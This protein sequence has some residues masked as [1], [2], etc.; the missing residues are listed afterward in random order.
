VLPAPELLSKA[1]QIVRHH[2]A[3]LP[4]HRAMI[5]V[6]EC[7]LVGNEDLPRP[8]L[9]V[10]CGDGHFGEVCL[11]APIDA[12]IDPA[13]A[14]A[15]EARRRGVYR[16]VLVGSGARLPF[17]DHTFATVVSNCVLEHIPALDATLAEIARVLRPGGKLVIT[18]PSERFAESLFWSRTLWRL[19]W[20]DQAAAYGRWFNRISYHYHTYSR[21]E[22][23]GRL[24]QAGLTVQSWT[25]YL[26]PDAM[27]FF[28]LS[29]Y[30]GAPTLLSKRLTGRWILW[31]G[32]SR[33]LPWEHWL[34]RRLEQ[35]AS[36]IAVP[37]GAY[38]FFTATK[39]GY[40]GVNGAGPGGA[41]VRGGKRGGRRARSADGAV[42]APAAPPTQEDAPRPATG[43][44][45]ARATAAA[46]VATAAPPVPAAP[47]TPEATAAPPLEPV[48]PDGQYVEY[49]PPAASLRDYLPTLTRR[50]PARGPGEKAA[51]KGDGG[52][53]RPWPRW[54]LALLLLILI[55]GAALRFTGVNWDNGHHLHP[56]ERFLTMVE[57][58]IKPGLV[59]PG[60]RDGQ[61]TVQPASLLD[62]YFDT[63]RSGLNPHN[64]GFGFFVYGT[65]PLFAVRWLAEVLQQTGYGQVHLLGRTL[66][67]LS[68]LATVGLIYLIGRRLYGA[69]VGLLAAALLAFCVMHIQQA[70]FFVFDSFLVTLIT[71]CFYACVDVAETGRLRSFALAG[72]FLGL[73]L[74]TKLSMVVFAPI[75]ALAGLIYLWRTHFGSPSAATTPR[76]WRDLAA[77]DRFYKV[78]Y[79]GMLAVAV[80]AL[81]FRV[82]QPYA[83]SGPGF[84]GVQLNPRWLDNIAYQAKTQDGTV[85]LP[86]SI[87]WAGTTPL[88]FPWQHMVAWGMGIPLGLTAWIGFGAAV[89]VILWRGRWQHLLV[90]AW[91]GVCFVYFASVLNK[92]MRYLLPAYPFL[93]LLG[94]WALVALYFKFA[95]HPLAPARLRGEGE[96]DVEGVPPPQPPAPARGRS[97]GESPAGAAPPFLPLSP[98]SSVLRPLLRWGAA[99]LMAFVVV[100]SAA[101]SFA[102]TRIYTRPVT[103][104]AASEWI[105][106]HVPRGSV[107]ANEH[108]DDPL[109]LPIPGNDPGFY[110]GPQLPLYDPD[111]PKKLD[112]LVQMLTQADYINL[113]SNRL[114]GSIPRMP[115]RYPMTTEYY[116]RLFAG[117]LGFKLVK[118]FTSYPT[119]GPWVINDDRAEEAFTVYDHPKVLIFEKQPDFSPERVRQVLGAV[120]LENVVQVPPA[121]AD[122]TQ[123]LMPPWLQAANTAGGTWSAMFNPAGLENRLAPLLWYLVLQGAGLLA[124]PLLWYLLPRLP[125]RGYG[126]AKPL[127]LLG[128]GWLAWSLA[129]YRLLPWSRLAIVV[130]MVLMGAATAAVLWRHGPA[131][132]AW[133]RAHRRV[134]LTGEAVFLA[135]FVLMLLLRA[136]NPDLWHTA[137]GGEKPMEFSYFNAVIRTTYFPPYDPW[138][139]GGYLNYYYFGYVLVAAVTKLTGVLP[140]IAFNLAVAVFYAL[141]AGGCFSFAYN[142]SRLVG[143]PGLG[144]GAALG[145]GVAGA[146]LVAFAGNLDG[147]LQL[148]ERLIRA[149]AAT[150]GS[151]ALQGLTP[152]SAFVE[153][154]RGIS[155]VLF[156][157]RRLESF[158]YWRSSRVIPNNTINEF[159]Y[160]TFLFADLHA[161]LMSLPYQV[162]TLGVM[163]N[164]AYGGRREPATDSELASVADGPPLRWLQWGWRKALSWRRV[165]EIALLSWLLGALYVINSWEFPTYLLAIAATFGIAEYTAQRGL[166]ATGL[167]R[168]GVAA[169]A[170]LLLVKPFFAPFWRY[171][172][173]FYSSISRWTEDRSGL[174]AYLTIHGLLLFLV[175]TLAVAMGL[176][177][178]RRSGWM[179]YLL[180]RWCSV[181]R[182]GGDGWRRFGRLE[183]ALGLRRR[184]PA[185]GYVLLL[186]GAVVL[187]L[188]LGLGGGSA[189]ALLLTAL[190]ALV[191][192]ASW[193]NR[194]SAGLLVAGLLSATGLALGIFVEFFTLQGDIGRMNTVFKFY[195]QT[196]VMWGLVSAVALVWMLRAPHGASAGFRVQRSGLVD[197]SEPGTPN[198]ALR[199]IARRV[200]LVAAAGL[201]L[202]ALAF[203]LAGTPARLADRFLALPPTLDGMA[204]M[205]HVSFTDSSQEVTARNPGGVTIHPAA[206]EAAIEWLLSNVQGSPVVLE[207]SVPEYRWGTRVAMYTGLPAVLGWRWHQ[208]QQRGTY[209]PMVDQRL[210]DVQTMFNDPSPNRVL[211]LLK[212]YQ[213]RYVYVGALERAYYT[214]AG[215]IKF[216]QQ[217]DLFNPVY[218][219]HGVTIYEVAY[220]S[221]S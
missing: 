30:Y 70:H 23:I 171:Y 173:T 205:S 207:A 42:V 62:S 8:L 84:F 4:V 40:L 61:V 119:L 109:P 57:G 32:K 143:R 29:H 27:G 213:V 155:A 104:V 3:T 55:A 10:G 203:P 59:A 200:W 101:W 60:A 49:E 12:G 122:R 131:W 38:Y 185:R 178:W 128:V 118:T 112:T 176:P 15:A 193:E 212:K 123:L 36:Q 25:S 90:V 180:A 1:P 147:F 149:G 158:D 117:E 221:P 150:Q 146:L 201:L 39:D 214:A 100:A 151:L 208:V 28:D 169:A 74:A 199:A 37:D 41:R 136:A 196:W 73:A 92:T 114:Y 85:D 63:A 20:H 106:Q 124:A 161:H 218:R 168:A 9:D 179:R 105:Y 157:G 172:E 11:G 67:A 68:D 82:F 184:A 99:G 209:A 87:Q 217:T 96:Q 48:E 154:L 19:G 153:L 141:L 110:R 167:L 34:E 145:A 17:R 43:D 156:D 216:D 138:F 78:L 189:V 50:Q 174:G 47:P 152:V 58:A 175:V 182:L 52:A 144:Q 126:L 108:W 195:L 166:T 86:P 177:G 5:R 21:D 192:A 22:W 35:F 215:L 120:P 2:L 137:R 115:Q 202:A 142:L 18:V 125:D 75:V 165:G 183:G 71:A 26:S 107:L 194:H 160:W 206:D 6:V 163:L 13:P 51:P 94:A 44:G 89:A 162:A 129:S 219:Q 191:L 113:T 190:L 80:A 139:A 186:G 121:R 53:R 170:T 66:S 204:Y 181:D 97:G 211:P 220:G 103:R 93:I 83:F 135:A 7:L 76:A 91:S 188:G 46:P 164:V 31:P 210:R 16:Q 56:D 198:P 148:L 45:V 24:R 54:E 79:G 132:L 130:A 140:S 72:T 116:R 69:R 197:N 95:P 33:L 88:L 98:P 81:M 159:P 77:S 134:V 14:S 102:F 65:F 127:G 111:E 133:L 187:G 64:V